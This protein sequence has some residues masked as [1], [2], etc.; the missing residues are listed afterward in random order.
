MWITLAVAAIGAGIQLFGQVMQNNAL[1]REATANL[2]QAEANTELGVLK[3]DAAYLGALAKN[4]E[5]QQSTEAE[6]ARIEANQQRLR[7]VAIIAAAVLAFIIAIV[8]TVK[9]RKS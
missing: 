1:K 7:T 8:L 5:T 3:A 2:T 4:A 6:K 9:A